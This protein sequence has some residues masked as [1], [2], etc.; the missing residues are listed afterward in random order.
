MDELT[1][2]NN[3]SKSLGIRL[4]TSSHGCQIDT[5]SHGWKMPL[6]SHEQNSRNCAIKLLKIKK[7]H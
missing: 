2:R 4:D 1:V 6:S 7:L 5:S 3:F